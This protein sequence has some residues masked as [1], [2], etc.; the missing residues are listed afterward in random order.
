M[1]EKEGLIK[2]VGTGPGSGSKG[3]SKFYKQLSLNDFKKLKNVDYL[4]QP[5]N[6][7][8]INEI[9]KLSG[10]SNRVIARMIEFKFIKP[11]ATSY[12]KGSGV[13]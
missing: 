2:S 5:K 1:C 8:N 6:T 11:L 7:Y 4:E 3:L 12:G 10:L 9:S 13:F